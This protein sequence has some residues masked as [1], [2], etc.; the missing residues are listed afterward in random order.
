[1][2]TF[3]LPKKKKRPTT[4][5][6]FS[7]LQLCRGGRDKKARRT[8]WKRPSSSVPCSRARARE[9]EEE[10]HDRRGRYSDRFARGGREGERK[11]PASSSREDDDSDERERKRRAGKSGFG[12][13]GRV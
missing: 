1:M 4:V 11:H 7:S 9:E 13:L 2:G 8:D 10:N 5:V 12:G 6:R 3:V